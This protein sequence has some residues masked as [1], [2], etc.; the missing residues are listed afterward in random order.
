[1]GIKALDPEKPDHFSQ[2]F[3]I[4]LLGMG[5]ALTPAVTVKKP[6]ITASGDTKAKGIKPESPPSRRQPGGAARKWKRRKQT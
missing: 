3:E 1:M 6:N 2:I 5:A 4:S